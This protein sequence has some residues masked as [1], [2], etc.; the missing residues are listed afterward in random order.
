MRNHHSKF[1]LKRAALC[2]A[3]IG[4]LAVPMAFAATTTSFLTGPNDGTAREIATDYLSENG[5]EL[6]LSAADL[7]GYV[8]SDEYTSSKSGITHLYFNQTHEGIAIVNAMININVAR[9]GSVISLG[10]RF[11]IG[12][13]KHLQP[14]TASITAAEAVDLAAAHLGLAPPVGVTVKQS[15][16]NAA[17]ET[18]LTGGG[19][20]QQDIPAR[21][22]Y[23]PQGESTHLAWELI[24]DRADE[25]HL[26]QTYVDASGGRVY[27]A[28]DMVIH[29]DFIAQYTEAHGVAPTPGT[30]DTTVGLPNLGSRDFG[31]PID[32]YSV[33]HWP[34]ENPYY[35]V[36]AAPPADGRTT[37]VDPA[38][39]GSAAATPFGW[40]NDGTTSFT[41]TQGNNVDAHK[42]A[43]R[44]DCGATLDC[45]PAIDLTIEPTV[46]PN[47]DA[48]TVNLFDW[49]N[50]MHDV[51]YNYGFTEAA[52]NF[53]EDNNGAGGLG[54]D[55]VNANAQ[56]AGNCNATFGTPA[57]GSNPTMNMFNCT[58]SVPAHDGDLDNAVIAHE[59][60]HGISNRLT[61]GPGNVNCLNNSEQGG[62][63]WSDYFGNVMT[64]EVGDAGTD[65]RGVGTWLLSQ[66]AGGAGIRPFPYS[67]DMGINPQT[68]DSIDGAAI[69]HG[70]GSVWA[71]M[72]W[73]M[74]WELI[75]FGVSQ[76]GFDPDIYNGTG[77]NNLSMQLV[78][79]GMKLQPCS[80]GF[81]DA[82]DAILLA[83]LNNNA[84][85]N[86]CAIWKAF[87]KRGLGANALQG[88]TGSTSDGTEDFTIPSSCDFLGATIDEVSICTPDDAVYTISLGGAW[89]PPVT[90][91]A[92]GNPAGTTTG[93][94]VNP[95]PSVPNTSDLTIGSTAGATAGTYAMNVHGDDTVDTFDLGLVL[96]V[97]DQ[98]PGAPT[99][100]T[101]SDTATGVST[102]PTLE[103]NAGIQ[104]DTDYTVEIDDDPAFGSIDYT[105][106]ETGGT[107]HV[108]TANLSPLTTYYWRIRCANP[109]GAGVNSAVFSFETANV[110]CSTPGLA[111]PDNNPAGVT[112]T[113][114]VADS[115]TLTD[116]DI[117]VELTHTWVG[118]L[119]IELEKVGGP[120]IDLVNRP[121]SCSSDDYDIVLDDEGTGGTIETTCDPGPAAQSPPNYVPDGSLADYDGL[122]MNGDWNLN[123]SDNAGQDLGVLVEWCFLPASTVALP[124]FVDGFE[125][126]DTSAWSVTQP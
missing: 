36:V 94:S 11:D 48:A 70:V 85:V 62:E 50:L 123:V 43:V 2:L 49:N 37:E 32:N 113:I 102:S 31:P 5:A 76:S 22:V 23:F 65:S 20:S 110:I 33:Y 18:L 82:R 83:D 100:T 125:S 87:A 119:I 69:P 26:W 6:G 86:Q 108:V 93:F 9:D 44:F 118:D 120:T 52:G 64:I 78:M 51:W 104:C 46:Q 90:L 115:S 107:T 126:G 59:Y 25:F 16:D 24:I 41:N 1:P 56:A 73:E 84:G 75:D 12:L 42:G 40:H 29:E 95:V 57:D 122:A 53:Q 54:G 71:T 92:T 30:G 35:S 109:C 55:G 7:A 99:L 121:G 112:D 106:N 72:L 114:T 13:Q 27:A 45:T 96:N 39:D 8:I 61:G 80:P 4:V 79:D 67:T 98:T 14:S 21:L 28:Q 15:S 116:L 47:V 88:S 10:N 111:I 17:Q 58:S 3:L 74:T 68:Y 77:G 124:I 34:V 81:V 19:V 91:S 105:A 101:P 117:S 103:W 63:G 97:F 60:G 89:S 38:S 66:G